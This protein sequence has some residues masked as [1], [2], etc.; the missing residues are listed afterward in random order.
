MAIAA[1]A[2]AAAA[3]GLSTPD[4]SI[5]PTSGLL[6]PASAP[7]HAAMPEDPMHGALDASH[8]AVQPAESHAAEQS[9]QEAALMAVPAS[10]ADATHASTSAAEA[11]TAAGGL[12]DAEMTD[13]PML[14]AL[15]AAADL[16]AAQAPE[17]ATQ[18]YPAAPM[19]VIGGSK[20]QHDGSKDA[21]KAQQ[22]Q[23][24]G[25]AAPEASNMV[26]LLQPDGK[27][28]VA[29]SAIFTKVSPMKSKVGLMTIFIS[30]HPH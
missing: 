30:I 9:A 29:G 27:P 11:P 7:A 20:E 13:A 4:V 18:E 10:A 21:S 12:G 15:Q 26:Q 28:L 19:E 5:P 3:I 25:E 22:A 24:Q 16:H 23:Q 2:A 6:T 14:N 1:N 17:Q 8:A